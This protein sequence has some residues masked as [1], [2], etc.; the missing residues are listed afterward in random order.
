MVTNFK[1]SIRN[2]LVMLVMFIVMKI[3]FIVIIAVKISAAKL[4]F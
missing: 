1:D 4:D 2:Q 3:M